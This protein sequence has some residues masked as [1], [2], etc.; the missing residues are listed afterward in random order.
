MLTIHQAGAIIYADTLAIAATDPC[1]ETFI[2]DFARTVQSVRS[3]HGTDMWAGLEEIV[4]APDRLRY[5][6]PPVIF[7]YKNGYESTRAIAWNRTTKAVDI[8][9]DGGIW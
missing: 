6:S 2:A 8:L 3:L 5:G 4:P 1:S 7:I 9:V